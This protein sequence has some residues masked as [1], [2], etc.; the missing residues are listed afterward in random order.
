VITL[1]SY[2]IKGGVGKTSTVVNLAYLAHAEGAR[3]L[4]WDLDP[5]GA[6]TFMFRVRAKVKGGGKG[7]V[8]G[9]RP[10]HEAIRGSDYEG[11]DLLPADFSYRNLDLTLNGERKSHRRLAQL[12][13]QLRGD[14][15]YVF[16]DCAPAI[17]LASEAIFE[18][19]QALLVPTIPTVLSLR[20]LERLE[21]HMRKH[22][23]KSRLLPYFCMVDRR[24]KLHRE[25]C[26]REEGGRFLESTIPYSSAVE[27]MSVERAPLVA[28]S[29]AS[30][31]ARAYRELWAEIAERVER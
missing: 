14:Y 2:S 26:L 24:K 8:R 4:L 5:Q 11:L 28:I 20:T 1:A 17:S 6:A 30:A 7:L 15:D 19:S 31:A 18:A 12:L 29:R 22:S 25:F 9:K 21:K 13:K 27:R 3:V 16:L 10:M 23:I